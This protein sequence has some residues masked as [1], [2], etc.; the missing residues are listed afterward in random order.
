MLTISYGGKDDIT[1]CAIVELLLKNSI[2]I[3]YRVVTEGEYTV[4]I[5]FICC[6]LSWIIGILLLSEGKNGIRFHR[7]I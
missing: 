4:R 5:I 6:I 1:R 7:E 2:D 3:N